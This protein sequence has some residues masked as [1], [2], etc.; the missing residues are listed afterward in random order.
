MPPYGSL[1]VADAQKAMMK[2]VDKY[3]IKIGEARA[4]H[5][6]IIAFPE[7]GLYGFLLDRESSLPYLENIPT[8]DVIKKQNI[9]PCEQSAFN[10]RP[11]LQRMSCLAKQHDIAIVF[12]MGDVQPCH[13]LVDINC[14]ITADE[15]KQYNT[16]V[17]IDSDGRLLAKYHKRHLYFEKAFD[18][19]DSVNYA[20]FTT[21]F[22]VYF[23]MFTCFD[24]LF[25]QPAIEL[26]KNYSVANIVFP[27]AWINQFP[28][29]AATEV[30]QAWSRV[31]SV[32]VLAANNHLPLLGFTGSGIYS[33]GHALKSFASYAENIDT[34]LVARV[35]IN[36]DDVNSVPSD[37]YNVYDGYHPD[38][39]LG[40]LP[41]NQPRYVFHPLIGKDGRALA[42]TKEFCCETKYSRLS[43]NEFYAFGVFIG[44][45]KSKPN[46]YLMHA[47]M[48][49]KC[50]NG[51]L[52]SCGEPV[53]EAS[54]AFS[55][56]EIVSD[57]DDATVF[58]MIV[59]GNRNLLPPSDFA[60][61]NPYNL[62]SRF[63]PGKNPV[64]MAV[65][66]YGRIFVSS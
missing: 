10:D 16:D 42:C 29:L 31:M 50:A 20:T 1:S 15:R 43:D 55:F 52:S 22:G 54:T 45:D 59:T 7:D 11:I 17:A 33:A 38:A 47:C 13:P 21:S 60:F 66:L 23:G 63:Q 6:Q 4:Q 27:T 61:N 18:V 9:N 53:Y 2:N 30:Q 65:T 40:P 24:I 35:P 26:V 36:P 48:L 44:I 28:H 5:A 14:R 49:T 25:K 8:D 58:P 56:V 62:T 37:G 41:T 64:L 34:L 12:N 19:P 3:E 39:V 46:D 51:S 32:N 57:H